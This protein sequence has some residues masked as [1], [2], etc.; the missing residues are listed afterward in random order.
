MTVSVTTPEDIVNGATSIAIGQYF[1]VTGTGNPTYLV[2]DA[3]DR[4][5]YTVSGNGHTGSFIGNGATLNLS[6]TGADGRGCGIVYT[7]QASS[8]QYVNATY[9]ALAQLTY[10][11]SDSQHD[12]TNISLFSTSSASLAQQDANDAYALMQA[13]AGGFIGSTTIVTDPS[14]NGTVPAAATPNGVASVAMGYV[15]DAWNQNG[16]WVLASTIAAEAGASLPV[17][18]TAV[19]AAGK[20]NG[21][22]I[23]LYNGPA[24]ANSTASWQNLVS[25][26]DIICFGTGGG[27]GHITTCVSGSGS[28]AMLVDNITYE[29][30]RGQITNS[31]NDGSKSDVLIA[32]PH[33][34]SQEWSGVSA[35]SVVIYALDTPAV[36]D[37]ATATS[38][39][40]AGTS[41]AFSKLFSISDPANKAI[42][43]VE[44]YESSSVDTLTAGTAATTSA[45][46]ES[47]AITATSLS[48]I[49]LLTAGSGTDTIDVRAFNGAYW[50]D[51]QSETINV[52]AL[53][54]QAPVLGAQTPT[55]NWKQGAHVSLTLPASVFTDPQHEALT[56]SAGN[57]PGWL[58]FDPKLRQF[59]GT[60]PSGVQNFAVVVT[61][62][63]TA[64]LSSSETFTVN[65]AA[66]APVVGTHAAAQSWAEN[67]SISYALPGN[68][69]SDPQGQA[70]TYTAT[71]AGGTA[72]PSWLSFSSDSLSFSG[73]APGTAQKLSLKVTATDTS[74]L[75][76][77]ETIS[78]S[79][80]KGTAVGAADWTA[81]YVQA[82]A[83][84]VGPGWQ[85]GYYPGE[86]GPVAMDLIALHH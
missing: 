29:N 55:Q 26:G 67:S 70:L 8:H 81:G 65:V 40:T 13:D 20:A 39:V 74:G 23:V 61:A 59:S 75:S 60:V 21:E 18:S 69:F 48:A 62:T 86:V 68:S 76:T 83:P 77:S 28:T 6:A 63:D 35:G 22:W 46:S 79:V 51:W 78:V 80:V 64:G 47:S 14:F 10:T 27:G 50:G 38:G 12:M 16:C 5:E 30:S 34:A 17:Q 45:L 15:G 43:K 56:Y 2:V 7:W 31:A 41:V 85:G 54:P 42:T 36:T 66:L 33:A 71:Q 49:G 32:S 44:V 37:I 19:G 82:A 4:N 11:A 9:G 3:I 72:L 73:T 1:S 52:A 84:V 57:L 58:S 53:V 25:T 24:G